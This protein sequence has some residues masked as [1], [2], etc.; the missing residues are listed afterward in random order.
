M[1]NYEDVEVLSFQIRMRQD[2]IVANLVF[3]VPKTF[4]IKQVSQNELKHLLL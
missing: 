3:I 1:N 2:L 4:M